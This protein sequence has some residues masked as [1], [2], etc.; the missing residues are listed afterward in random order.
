M[1]DKLTWNNCKDTMPGN[2]FDRHFNDEM[3]VPDEFIFL[4]MYHHG[5][6]VPFVCRADLIKG[7]FVT[8]EYCH[9][10]EECPDESQEKYWGECIVTHWAHVQL[11]HELFYD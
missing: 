6:D 10:Y 8:S 11:P 5:D 2:H 9:S 4:V 1:I 7:F 3:T